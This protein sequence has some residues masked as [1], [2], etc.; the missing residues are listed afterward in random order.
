MD[1]DFLM[2]P[3]KWD[4]WSIVRFMVWF[5]PTSSVFDISMF[6]FMW[7]NLGWR[8]PDFATFFETGWFIESLFTQTLIVH[9]IRSPK[10]PLIQSTATWQVW[11]ATVL[12][13]ALG[14]FLTVSPQPLQGALGFEYLPTSLYLFTLAMVASYCVLTNIVK[15]IYLW[16]FKGEWF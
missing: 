7:F 4:W 12:I 9:M 13:I 3:H 15:N 8:T 16:L 11:V 6:S 1:E 5:G 10:L 14:I 2:V